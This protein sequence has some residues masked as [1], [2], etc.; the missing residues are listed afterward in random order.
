M[1]LF[2]A[3]VGLGLAVGLIATA[4]A[5]S[6]PSDDV[7]AAA[8]EA[9]VDPQQ[10]LGAV[11]TTHLDARAY[12]YAVGELAR[13]FQWPT[14]RLACIAR[15]ES[16]ND[17][18]ATN[19]RSGAAGLFQFLHGTWLSTPQGKAGLSPYDPQAATDAAQW[20]VQQGRIREW[21]AVSGG[22]C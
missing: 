5:D 13:P 2:I 7:L 11:N 3:G 22:Y 20:M 1:R 19:P 21:Q 15:V 6:E 4:R 10:L 17:P 14:G 16:R 8:Q 12:L 18:N 9:N